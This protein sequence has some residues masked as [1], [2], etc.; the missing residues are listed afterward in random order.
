MNIGVEKQK[1]IMM[2]I[3]TFLFLCIEYL[4]VDI[5]SGMVSEAKAVTIQNYAL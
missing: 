5:V 1:T 4:Y 3:F 2:G